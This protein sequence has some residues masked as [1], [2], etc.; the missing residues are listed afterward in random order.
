MLRQGE[1]F[2]RRQTL[3]TAAAAMVGPTSLCNLFRSHTTMI[4]SV[5]LTDIS[6]FVVFAGEVLAGVGQPYQV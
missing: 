2:V 1:I 4:L 5:D 3:P 6:L